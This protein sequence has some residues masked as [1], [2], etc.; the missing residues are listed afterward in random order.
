MATFDD[1][2][3]GESITVSATLYTTYRQC[4]QQALGRL[5]GFYP[6]TTRASFKGSLAH[7]IFAR[8]LESGPIAPDDFEMVCRQEVGANLGGAMSSLHLKP[9]DFRS[10]VT[11]VGDL[12]QRFDAIPVDGFLEAEALLDHEPA[13]GVRLRGRVDAV[14]SDPG[15]DAVRIVDWKTGHDLEG[16][17]P[18]LDFY[19]MA[20]TETHGQQPASLEALS[21]RTG[22]KVVV[23]PS[24]SD[25]DRVKGEVVSMIEELRTAMESDTDL[26]RTAGPYCRWC[27][28][29]DDC[30][31]GSVALAILA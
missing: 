28:L 1:L 21:L 13:S 2:A 29:L 27:P 3:P 15:S 24:H 10:L 18:Q 7:R 20:W 23:E 31:E 17:K 19:A 8:H 5:Q 4:P 22:E 6:P 12:Y 30:S 26:P 9:S 16:S 25:I 14:F 11:E